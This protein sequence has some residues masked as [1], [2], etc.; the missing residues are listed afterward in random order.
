MV[1][2]WYVFCAF[3][4]TTIDRSTIRFCSSSSSDHS[5]VAFDNHCVVSNSFSCAV[6]ASVF[7]GASFRLSRCRPYSFSST[8]CS[9][10][11]LSKLSDLSLSR[12]LTCDHSQLFRSFCYWSSSF[13]RSIS[14]SPSCSESYVHASSLIL[15]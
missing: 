14:V 1:W 11:N 12:R 15:G 13:S 9:W 3:P 5:F 8:L 10:Y 2:V 6:K 7:V 4:N